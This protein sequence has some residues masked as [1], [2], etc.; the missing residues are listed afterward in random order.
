MI[1]SAGIGAYRTFK[2]EART[3]HVWTRGEPIGKDTARGARADD[4]EVVA[5]ATDIR[6]A[7][8]RARDASRCA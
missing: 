2:K 7:P 4:D 3:L 6:L 8:V 1:P 5:L